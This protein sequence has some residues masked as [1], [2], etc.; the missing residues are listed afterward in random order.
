MV[1]N[2]LFPPPGTG[3]YFLLHLSITVVLP[4]S[5]LTLLRLFFVVF[6]HWIR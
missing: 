2:L 6:R 1:K 3:L 5:I 4:G